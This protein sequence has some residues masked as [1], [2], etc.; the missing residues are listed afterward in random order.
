VRA[1]AELVSERQC[2]AVIGFRVVG[3]D[4]RDDIRAR[5]HQLDLQALHR[6]R[7]PL[8]SHRSGRGRHGEALPAPHSVLPPQIDNTPAIATSILF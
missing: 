8:M 5:P 3:A 2:L 7:E 4:Y 1:R 6:V